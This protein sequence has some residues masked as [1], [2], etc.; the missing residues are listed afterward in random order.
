[1]ISKNI[2]REHILKAIKEVDNQGVPAGRT[3]RKFLLEFKGKEYP[4][5][6]LIS[7]ANK[8]ANGREL[9]SEDFS[10][11]KESNEFLGAETFP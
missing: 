7:I 5:K 3:S 4:A 9:D 8:Y 11:G 2:T 1:M 6:Y 10:G